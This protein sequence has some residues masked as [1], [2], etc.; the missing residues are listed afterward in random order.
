MGNDESENLKINSRS[1]SPT[2]PLMN[3]GLIMPGDG[4]LGLRSVGL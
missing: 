1:R 4:F 3:R 2:P